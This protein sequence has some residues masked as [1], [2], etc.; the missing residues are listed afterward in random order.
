MSYES[1][2]RR[3]LGP[4]KLLEAQSGERLDTGTAGAASR[5]NQTMEAVGAVNGTEDESGKGSRRA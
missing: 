2:L 1:R 5:V 3:R 4:G